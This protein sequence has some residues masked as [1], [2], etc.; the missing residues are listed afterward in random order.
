MD[1]VAPGPGSNDNPDFVN[2]IPMRGNGRFQ[3]SETIRI[4][5]RERV[6]LLRLTG[7]IDAKA[8]KHVCDIE[9]GTSDPSLPFVVAIGVLDMNMVVSNWDMP[10]ALKA[11]FPIGAQCYDIDPATSR[12]IRH[13]WQCRPQ[14]RKGT[15]SL[16]DIS[17][18]MFCPGCGAREHREISA[19][20]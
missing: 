6:E 17:T 4:P 19:L 16:E 5:E 9:K 8:K 11:V 10:A 1:A 20:L 13:R 3:C 15:K 14:I 12:F 2:E 18:Q 7:A